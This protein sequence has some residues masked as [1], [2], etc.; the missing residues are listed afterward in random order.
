MSLELIRLSDSISRNIN[1]NETHKY[2][3]TLLEN[4]FLEISLE[5]QGIDLSISLHN[6]NDGKQLVINGLAFNYLTK[7][8]YW[9]TKE[10]AELVLTISTREKHIS[11]GSYKL[12]ISQLR[13]KKASDDN[14][15]KLQELFDE[16]MG[17]YAEVSFDSKK[18]ALDKLLLLLTTA[19]ELNLTEKLF[20]ALVLISKLY[21]FLG[22]P[23]KALSYIQEALTLSAN[24]LYKKRLCLNDIGNI[25]IV[26]E[27]QKALEFFQQALDIRDEVEDIVGEAVTLGNLGVYYYDLEEIKKALSYYREAYFLAEQAQNLYLQTDLLNNIGTTYSSLN[28]SEKALECYEKSLNIQVQ[29]GMIT[30]QATTLRNIGNIYYQYYQEFDKALIYYNESLEISSSSGKLL[31][32]ANALN[33]IALV[34]E[35]EGYKD[36]AL[37]NYQEALSLA[38]TIEDSSLQI[39][40]L[41]NIGLFYRDLS[42]FDKSLDFLSEALFLAKQTNDLVHQQI[43]T[44]N[45]GI[46]FSKLNDYKTALTYHKESLEL[47]INLKNKPE[48]IRLLTEIENFESLLLG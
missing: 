15:L 35:K 37:E 17:L 3:V 23:Q 44:R 40:V 7:K 19:K 39:S 30:K 26:L 32:K 25:Y 8:L 41:N 33:S 11:P 42:E 1:A 6:E 43:V 48:E 47:S 46:T 34:H 29:L 4:Q 31:E 21:D 10:K 27:H 45:L 22:F 20:E 18:K 5:Q 36:E 14:Y 12:T 24:N 38:K 13:T 2:K 16:S 9:V 28:E